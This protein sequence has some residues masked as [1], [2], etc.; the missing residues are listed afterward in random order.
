MFFIFTLVFRAFAYFILANHFRKEFDY[1]NCDKVPFFIFLF[2]G[3]LNLFGVYILNGHK[4]KLVEYLIYQESAIY[5]LG[6][7]IISACFFAGNNN[8]SRTDK[9]S[10]F[11][12]YFMFAFIIAD[13][14]SAVAYY[15]NLEWFHFLDRGLYIYALFLMVRYTKELS[16]KVV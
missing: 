13:L 2:L 4:K 9:A 1:K 15:F 16:N 12:A 10:L 3:L 5:F 8:Y 7:A 14:C 11:G 6:L